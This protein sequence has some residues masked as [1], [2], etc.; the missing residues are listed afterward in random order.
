VLRYRKRSEDGDKDNP[1]EGI[2]TDR[3]IITRLGSR[4]TTLQNL[5]LDNNVITST[6]IG[7]LVETISRNCA[8]YSIPPTIH[9]SARYA[10]GWMQEME[11]LRFRNRFLPLIRAPKERLLPT[12]VWPHALARVAMLPNV[13]F[14]VLHS[15]SNLVP[16]EDTEGKET[17]KDTS[18]PT[19]RKRGDE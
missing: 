3:L 11:R 7:V 5:T 10:G 1:D 19:K 12:G 2:P 17:A 15:K 4:K 8:S 18:V 9:E 14:E 13:I 6:G 16:F